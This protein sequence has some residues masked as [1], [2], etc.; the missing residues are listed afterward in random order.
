M[1]NLISTPLKTVL[2][3]SDQDDSRILLRWFLSTSGYVVE[4][5]RNAPEA[6][7][8]FDPAIH[9]MIV[10]ENVMPGMSGV[11]MAHIIKLRSPTTPVVMY[12]GNP[13]SDCSCLNLVVER[14][15]HMLVLKMG[16]D[17]VFAAL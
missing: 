15:A 7:S 2:L 3:V 13:P 16:M 11:E 10:T 6:M 12:T 14:S 8:V 4:S 1:A 17:R 5:V 9:D